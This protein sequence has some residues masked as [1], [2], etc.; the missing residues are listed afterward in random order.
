MKQAKST[1]AMLILLS[2]L[3]SISM[4]APQEPAAESPQLEPIP[5]PD[6]TGLEP[7]V[8][9]QIEAAQEVFPQLLE[10]S[11]QQDKAES[12]GTL[13]QLYHSYQMIDAARVCYGNAQKLN[14]RDFRWPYYQA[15]ILHDAGYFSRAK[16]LY[17]QAL[18]IQPLNI[19]AMVH[20]AKTVFE[21]GDLDGSRATFEKVLELQPDTGAA[22]FGM[23]QIALSVQNYQAAAHFLERTLELVPDASAVHYPLALAYQQ[24]GRQEEAKKHLALRGPVGVGVLDPL[25]DQLRQFQKGE[26]VHLL[27]GRR[28]LQAG[29]L[30]AALSSFTQAVEASPQSVRARNNLASALAALKRY[31]EAIRQYELVLQVA[32]EDMTALFNLGSLTLHQE[33]FNE[34]AGYLEKVVRASP[35]DSEAFAL[36]GRAL[37]G[38]GRTDQA[39]IAFNRTLSLDPANESA[40]LNKADLLA[41]LGRYG[42]LRTFLERAYSQFPRDGL[43]AHALARVLASCPDAGLRDG[44]KALQLALSVF[45]ARQTHFHA[46]TVAEAHAETGNCQDA[47]QWQSA[48]VK[49]LE[50]GGDPSSI[51]EARATLTRYQSGPPCRPPAQDIEA[52]SVP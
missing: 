15:R 18:S 26:I 3:A 30:E 20:L 22:T 27:R 33:R 44:E 52:P 4:A 23:A 8:R 46:M 38:V 12:Y 32:P 11:A 37:R 51:E 9:E 13:G 5:N 7:A 50:K 40:R 24:L 39:M 28:A 36:L 17:S 16:E 31:E 49:A 6:L 35:R 2:F 14:P 25:M 34:A 43:T 29:D 10:S 47:A 48:V 45:E 19:P 1:F 21:E 41:S 42:E